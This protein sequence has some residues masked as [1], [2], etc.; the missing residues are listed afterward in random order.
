MAYNGAQSKQLLAFR[1]VSAVE[2]LAFHEFYY[3]PKYA[4]MCELRGE[5]PI[6]NEVPKDSKTCDTRIE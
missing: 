1:A 5:L 3:C 2:C 6:A 4:G